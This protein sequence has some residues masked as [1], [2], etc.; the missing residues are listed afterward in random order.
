MKA[1]VRLALIAMRLVS[2]LPMPL[3][4]GLGAGLGWVMWRVPNRERHNAQ[5]NLALC[6]PELDEPQRVVLLQQTLRHAGKTLL[7]M[8]ACWLGDRAQWLS[9][10]ESAGM[11]AHLRGKLSA[12]K[13]LILAAPHLGNWEVGV[14][15]LTEFAGPITILY[16]PPR[17]EWLE[18]ILVQGR[19]RGNGKVSLVPTTV[20]GIK[21]LY[22]AL[23]RGES[24][25]IL[26]DQ[27]PKKGE[28]GVF[29]PFFGQPALTMVLLSRLAAKTGAPVCLVYALREGQQFKAYWRDANPA[30]ADPDQQVAAAALNRDIEAC[31]RTAP[32]QYQWTYR[33]FSIRPERQPNPYQLPSD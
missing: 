11:Q 19:G 18:Q 17:Q 26:P 9:R 23:R 4:Q 25:A 21:A 10:I 5:V 6:F 2:R 27:Q 32:A 33:R 13:G 30:V 16:R 7:E 15:W 24:I 3:L 12:G 1:S 20:K 29:A 8:P 31:V 22:Q 28:G 14:H